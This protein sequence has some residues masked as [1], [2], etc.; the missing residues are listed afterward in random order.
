VPFTP[1]VALGQTCK[2]TI[3]YI[4]YVSM[5]AAGQVVDGRRERGDRSRSRVLDHG[6]ELATVYGLEGFSLSQ[7][8][9]ASG[10][11]K[12]GLTALFGSKHD[13]QD[14]IVGSA[15]EILRQRVFEPVFAA[16]RGLRRLVTLGAVW[17]DY[18]ADPQLRGGCFFSAASF[19]LD[20]RPGPL[21]ELVRADLIAWNVEIQHIIE[22]AQANGEITESVDAADESFA[23]VSLGIAANAMIQLAA[24]DDSADRAR[25]SWARHVDRLRSEPSPSTPTKTQKKRLRDT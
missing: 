12:A 19:E 25:R 20:A 4:V 3:V 16:P 7:L 24:T 17:L 23:F 6:V 21:R 2:R 11:T 8:A 10:L 13:L 1:N 14:A 18:L 15:R 9:D 22:D 5:N